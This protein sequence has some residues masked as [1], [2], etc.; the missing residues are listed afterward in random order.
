MSHTSGKVLMLSLVLLAGMIG[1]TSP[2]VA[3]ASHGEGLC[4]L[5]QGDQYEYETDTVYVT[6]ESSPGST[7]EEA[8]IEYTDEDG[9][10]DR[11]EIQ[12]IDA[13]HLDY[14]V[15]QLTALEKAAIA[16]EPEGE[17][18]VEEH[19]ELKQG[20][21]GPGYAGA[22]LGTDDE[23]GTDGV[24]R[25]SKSFTIRGEEGSISVITG[26]EYGGRGGGEQVPLLFSD[27]DHKKIEIEN[28]I[29]ANGTRASVIQ[30]R[31]NVEFEDIAIDAEIEST[32]N[33]EV[34][35]KFD[36][37]QSGAQ[38]PTGSVVKTSNMYYPGDS[39]NIRGGE[40]IVQQTNVPFGD[41]PGQGVDDYIFIQEVSPADSNPV[42]TGQLD[43]TGGQNVGSIVVDS[44]NGDD[45]K[46]HNSFKTVDA[47]V[48]AADRDQVI[49]IK[50]RGDAYERAEFTGL[51]VDE[52]HRVTVMGHDSNGDGQPDD[53]PTIEG[54]DISYP[55][56]YNFE[57]LH[58]SSP[59]EVKTT[60]ADLELSGNYWDNGITDAEDI[61]DTFVNGE[62]ESDIIN[63]SPLCEDENCNN[64]IYDSLDGICLKVNDEG[65]CQP[66][67]DVDLD[68]NLDVEPEE[69]GEEPPI[70][71][72]RNSS[73]SI[74][75]SGDVDSP[76]RVQ[77][78][79]L[80][81]NSNTDYSTVIQPGRE[82]RSVDSFDAGFS[83]MRANSVSPSPKFE[84]TAVVSVEKLGDTNFDQVVYTRDLEEEI[85]LR[86]IG[87]FT[88][89]NIFTSA[90]EAQNNESVVVDESLEGLVERQNTKVTRFS[91]GVT[92]KDFLDNRIPP[93]GDLGTEDTSVGTVENFGEL[94]SGNDNFP[95][96]VQ[97]QLDTSDNQLNVGFSFE[98]L[99]P[100][101][102][103]YLKFEYAYEAPDTSENDIE[104]DLVDDSGDVIYSGRDRQSE[105][106]ESTASPD[107]FDTGQPQRSDVTN[108]TKN[109]ALHP[110]ETQYIQN[111]GE[112]YLT[113]SNDQFQ[114]SGNFVPRLFVY[115]ATVTSTDNVENDTDLDSISDDSGNG[116]VNEPIPGD[117]NVEV[118]VSGNLNGQYDTYDVDPVNGENIQY[119][120]I[121]ENQGDSQVAGEFAVK[122]TLVVNSGQYPD[123]QAGQ[124]GEQTRIMQ[125]VSVNMAEG[126]TVT[127]QFSTDW[128]PEDFGFHEVRVIR[129]DIDTVDQGDVGYDAYVLQPPTPEIVN[130]SIPD[131]H[132]THDNF[133]SKIVI[134]NI[135]D[136]SGE[137]RVNSNLSPVGDTAQASWS[138][139][140]IR[141]LPEGD[142]RAG[143]SSEN[144]SIFY[145]RSNHPSSNVPFNRREYTIPSEVIAGGEEF[146]TEQQLQYGGGA[147]TY[148]RPNAPF[149][150]SKG[151]NR[152]SVEVE[153]Q[154]DDAGRG[155]SHTDSEEIYLGKLKVTDF[156]VDLNPT[157]GVQTG[158]KPTAEQ[159]TVYASAWPYLH[160]SEPSSVL[161]PY[162]NSAPDVVAEG[163]L[164]SQRDGSLGLGADTEELPVSRGAFPLNREEPSRIRYTSEPVDRYLSTYF[165]T[166][167]RA[168]SANQNALFDGET[169]LPIDQASE[170]DVS[171]TFIA[172]SS[173][174]CGAP[175]NNGQR[176]TE[177][178]GMRFVGTTDFN[179]TDTRFLEDDSGGRYN[180]DEHPSDRV[181]NGTNPNSFRELDERET[182]M[183][184]NVRIV[185]PVDTEHITT[186]R[187]EIV[188][189]QSSSQVVG[190]GGPQGHTVAIGSDRFEDNVVGAAAVRLRPE[191][192]I[193]FR[194]PI[195]IRNNEDADG[196]HELQLRPR[197]QSDAT[198][199]SSVDLS[200]NDEYI[201]FD[202]QVSSNDPVRSPITGEQHDRFTVPVKV[203]TYGDG[204]LNSL[205]LTDDLAH[206]RPTA[207]ENPVAEAADKY[208]YSVCRSN[209]A[210]SN[211]SREYMDGIF[212][213]DQGTYSNSLVEG[214]NPRS[215]ISDHSNRPDNDN[216][217][218]DLGVE[219]SIG[220]CRD[221]HDAADD[222]EEEKVV[223]EATYTNYGGDPITIRPQ[224]LGEFQSERHQTALHRQNAH[225]TGDRFFAD[226]QS[227]GD[228]DFEAMTWSSRRLNGNPFPEGNA[229]TVDPGETVNVEFERR[230][231]EPGLYQLRV[232]PCRKVSGDG[233]QHYNLEGFT[234]IPD[235]TEHFRISADSRQWTT[236]R[237][238]IDRLD[239]QGVPHTQY[240]EHSTPEIENSLYHG[241][242]GCS[243]ESAAVFVYDSQK[244]VAD[245]RI[246][247]AESTAKEIGDSERTRAKVVDQTAND[248]VG[249]NEA[250]DT[251]NNG[252][253][254]EFEI[255]EG[256]ILFFDGST[257]DCDRC[258]D[259]DHFEPDDDIETPEEDPNQQT[260][261]SE[262]QEDGTV[263]SH[264][265]STASTRITGDYDNTYNVDRY[266]DGT[267]LTWQISGENPNFGQES[268]TE[269][270]EKVDQST[271]DEHC[272]ME[273]FDPVDQ[274][275][276]GMEVVA[277]RFVNPSIDHE[278]E[279]T[280][281][282][283]PTLTRG[284]AHTNTTRTDVEVVE[285]TDDPNVETDHSLHNDLDYDAE[286]TATSG[287]TLWHRENDIFDNVGYRGAPTNFENDYGDDYEGTRMCVDVDESNTGDN[288]IGI[289]QDAWW[290]IVNGNREIIDD[291]GSTLVTDEGSYLDRSSGSSFN[292]DDENQFDKT[293]TRHGD[294]RCWAFGE[295]GP[296][297]NEER[298]QT[299]EYQVW[300]F[301][302]NEN[303]DRETVDVEHDS[304]APSIDTFDDDYRSETGNGGTDQFIWAYNPNVGSGFAGGDVRFDIEATDNG[305]GVGVACLDLRLNVG[306]GPSY[307]GEDI[308]GNCQSMG[309]ERTGSPAHEGTHGNEAGD[310]ASYTWVGTD[311]APGL[312]SSNGYFAAE[313]LQDNYDLD[314]G[315]NGGDS[316]YT[317][318]EELHATDWHGNH[319]SDTIDVDVQ[320]DGTPPS[321][322]SNN[323]DS[324]TTDHGQVGNDTDPQD[325]DK[326]T[327]VCGGF[328]SDGPDGGIAVYDYSVG[329]VN[330][331]GSIDSSSGP[332][333]SDREFDDE[334][335]VT[336]EYSDAFGSRGKEGLSPNPDPSSCSQCESGDNCD[337]DCDDDTDT[338]T[339]SGNVDVTIEDLHGNTATA[340]FEYD[341]TI[342]D[343]EKACNEE[344]NDCDPAGCCDSEEGC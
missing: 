130:I 329:N 243:A 231:Q 127:K 136:L 284:E 330:G 92:N 298:T 11:C 333:F 103:H 247:H 133:N 338:F 220:E 228:S 314:G 189:N 279:L 258:Y 82:T 8:Q 62:S 83:N 248:G 309:D 216:Y 198:D 224:L 278:V 263:F 84:P 101:S 272:Y 188:T 160:P 265:M 56:M 68:I 76:V 29:L 227:D 39:P 244:P 102:E 295:E 175:S 177:V 335:C 181:L 165:S 54:F 109:I 166:H 116:I 292:P 191:E 75:P 297:G 34:H 256:G 316:S 246:G 271:L 251:I 223:V 114:R 318:T 204:V 343:F 132:V 117:I 122:D 59:V 145:A 269:F 312:D 148:Y 99:P 342:D 303:H 119:E 31:S 20:G 3:S 253:S 157:E 319:A 206:N 311:S 53:V 10:T 69:G 49:Q 17:V 138:V 33:S 108:R 221:G 197:V 207:N 242:R 26:D 16:V 336:F 254:P 95:A 172:F 277:H 30:S 41:I 225:A 267:G 328:E 58:I 113:L 195:V 167:L 186:A 307:G 86:S 60:T 71:D 98:N 321:W 146:E 168:C 202:P 110:L 300:D 87:S 37:T 129:E 40:D 74:N 268:D 266:T 315:Y 125:E 208:A 241:S 120:L 131:E 51:G 222:Y 183:F 1:F 32:Q 27:N 255:H 236:A 185:N 70:T 260:F 257:Y 184:A 326:T 150:T 22:Y 9:N 261:R 215:G 80:E 128:G 73:V 55:G 201:E 234:G 213:S 121:F 67:E 339:T 210:E 112:I 152:L 4:N 296:N 200:G 77:V 264:R 327:Q 182:V 89:A 252:N 320:E 233:P 324:G 153:S 164:F 187:L 88:P 50:D 289:S 288:Q 226:Y 174:S 28:L 141:Q 154:Y 305:G 90:T 259:R 107:A 47:A 61:R 203:E 262:I 322:D 249:A 275:E 156:S 194:V 230:F 317:V 237:H 178:H 239:N 176:L 140:E 66:G 137:I 337:T 301:A 299:F 280:V 42:L 163:T 240:N 72:T 212:L 6:F 282:D 14:S 341:A 245:F 134:Q 293:E 123:D 155:L 161:R 43:F 5:A 111:N 139:D 94:R 142:S 235:Y 180:L 334:V 190:L 344:C 25:D 93:V 219:R 115:N 310:G 2:Q 274:G 209:P 45:E 147:N 57:N 104:I 36:A 199:D 173:E 38:I 331:D 308:H 106:L 171:D 44:A 229:A 48:K 250:H 23:A 100:A 211:D 7:S 196:V 18:I 294:K 149:S 340:N 192:E 126:E 281:Q 291:S 217:V 285:D 193:Q 19:P 81:T 323:F 52:Q 290:Q 97:P 313:E 162:G 85:K 65:N 159:A 64:L 15:D 144:T 46:I 270:C 79:I 63:V 302:E 179:R 232:S 105:L 273:A 96:V 286:S 218:E 35:F 91:A 214:L 287:S 118:G 306:S 12:N 205:E 158:N 151:T 304:N 143:Q 332:S 169:Q 325:S 78:S 170:S 283:D 21:K 276:A 238:G 124:T 13:S 24:L 135:G